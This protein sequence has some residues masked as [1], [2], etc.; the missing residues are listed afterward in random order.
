VVALVIGAFV[1]IVAGV[2]AAIALI[3][4]F[5]ERDRPKPT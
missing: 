5:G 2:F 4:L 1:L 3:L